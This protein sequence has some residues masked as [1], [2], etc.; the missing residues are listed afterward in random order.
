M[1][2]QNVVIILMDTAKLG[3]VTAVRE[4]RDTFLTSLANDG[5]EFINTFTSA[6]WSLPSHAS[7]FTSTY[8]S[9][10]GACARHTQ[11][12][13]K[14]ISLP[15]VFQDEGYETVAVSNNTWIS[16]EF[17]F[18]SGFDTFE[19]TWQ[20]VQSDVDLGR[21]ARTE[22]GV[23]KLTA[24][25][26]ELF[27]GNPFVNVAN[28]IYGQFFR[29]QHDDG[30]RQT[31]KW[32]ND[33]LTERTASCPFFLF[34]NYLEPHLEYRPPEEFAEQFLPPNI[35]YSDAMDVSQDA[36]GY[37]AGT[38]EMTDQD[39]DILRSLYRA[40]IA[41]L[42][43]RIGELKEYLEEQGEW[44]DTIFVVTGDHGENIGDHGLMDHQY[45]LYDTLLHVPLIIHGGSF[46]HKGVTDS[47]VQLT[48]LA[49]TLL[50]EIEIEDTEFDEQAQ[51]YSFHPDSETKARERITAEYLAPQPSMDALKKRV[52]NLPGSVYEYNRSLRAIRT[53]NW[54]LLRGSDGSVELYNINS[55]PSESENVVDQEPELAQNLEQELDEWLDS[56]EHSTHNGDVSMRDETKQRLED[57]GYLQ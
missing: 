27:A 6:P 4:Q 47:L 29:R 13:D 18:G 26:R 34:V 10:H 1:K 28:T 20:Y 57:L 7:I 5:T 54:K 50:D 11:L 36:F 37:I 32:I 2:G 24:L 14:F 3:A 45:C 53:E 46:S 51:G 42:D 48:D 15:E 21:I 55:D 23:D 12:S 38:V 33:W 52:G 22:D 9:K 25:G 19:K 41:Y 35:S 16:E 39:F 49:P 8:T 56:F 44:E 31:N 43:Y 30:A 40:E 17:G